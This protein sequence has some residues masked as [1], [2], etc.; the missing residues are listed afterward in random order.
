MKMVA[1]SIDFETCGIRH[2]TK[3]RPLVSTLALQ[4][5]KMLSKRA[6]RTNM[7]KRPKHIHKIIAEPLVLWCLATLRRFRKIEKPMSKKVP[8][9]SKI[10]Q[11]Q[12]QGRPESIYWM[13][14]WIWDR[15]A[16]SAKIDAIIE[17][18]K[19]SKKWA[20]NTQGAKKDPGA[21]PGVRFRRQAAT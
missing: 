19:Y 8:K 11:N 7:K 20:V 4:A 18:Q 21:S 2:G 17:V 16:K 15:F 1:P 13:M 9:W 6:S 14:L 5:P 10:N 12:P 3:S